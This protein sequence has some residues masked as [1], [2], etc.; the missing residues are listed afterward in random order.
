M[1]L[2]NAVDKSV[3]DEREIQVNCGW[4][5]FIAKNIKLANL[6]FSSR[7]KNKAIKFFI[8]LFMKII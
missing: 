1:L 6:I 8:F 5:V 7:E 3:I 2:Q 4:E